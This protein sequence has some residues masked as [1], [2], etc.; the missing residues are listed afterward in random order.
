[1]QPNFDY[2][3]QLAR[4]DEAFLQELKLVMIKELPQEKHNYALC[5]AAENLAGAAAMVHKM[6]HKV[7][8]LGMKEAY[9]QVQIYENA[10]RD[11]DQPDSLEF[12]E[13]IEAIFTFLDIPYIPSP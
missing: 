3:H 9:E 1:M 11:G 4:G 5:I 8:L 10:L 2:F 12:E 13:I 6:K 7:G